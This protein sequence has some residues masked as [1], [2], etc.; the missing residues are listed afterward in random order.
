MCGEFEKQPLASNQRNVEKHQEELGNRR[1]RGPIIP[2]I[3]VGDF[4]GASHL[5]CYAFLLAIGTCKSLALKNGFPMNRI[6]DARIGKTM[7]SISKISRPD[8]F[9]ATNT[10]G[11]NEN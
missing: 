9:N 4:A 2:G 11:I 8:W 6:H 10:G 7:Q 1:P 3:M 5:E